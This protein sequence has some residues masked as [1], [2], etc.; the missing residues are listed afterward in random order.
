MVRSGA[1]GRVLTE[2][3]V[4]DKVYFP[5]NIGNTH[6]TTVVMHTP[7]QEFQV[8]DSLYPLEFTLETVEALHKLLSL[9]SGAKLR[10]DM[11]VANE[12]TSGNHPDVSKWPILEYDMPQQHDGNSCGL[13]VME[14][15]EHW[16]GDRMTAEISQIKINGRRRR[17]VA[18]MMLSP[19]NTLEMVKERI[20]SVASRINKKT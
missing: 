8:L 19:S 4:R 14:C 7:K 10:D 9:Y 18:E 13:F 3:T 2:Y 11:Q 20:R 17:I 1:V 15:M 12:V 5:L 6:W 16:D